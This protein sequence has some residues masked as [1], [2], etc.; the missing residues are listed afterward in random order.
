[1]HKECLF[2]LL[3]FFIKYSV[4]MNQI[5]QVVL[6]SVTGHILLFG[7]ES[8]QPS[9]VVQQYQ[10]QLYTSDQPQ[11]LQKQQESLCLDP[12]YLIYERKKFRVNLYHSVPHN[13][14]NLLRQICIFPSFDH[15]F[16]HPFT[17][18]G[19]LMKVCHYKAASKQTTMKTNIYVSIHIVNIQSCSI[20]KYTNR[21]F[22]E[23]CHFLELHDNLRV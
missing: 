4:S 16:M 20:F 6:Y 12:R 11:Y 14:L 15:S 3:I 23:Y 1:M 5:L 7:K 13:L 21:E 22:I 8:Q 17:H 9:Q 18:G 2:C 19:E 10:E